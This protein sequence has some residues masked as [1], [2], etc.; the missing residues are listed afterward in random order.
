MRFGWLMGVRFRPA[1]AQG[2]SR[3]SSSTLLETTYRGN[4]APSPHPRQ[5][6]PVILRSIRCRVAA[7]SAGE[8]FTYLQ[9]NYNF[10]ERRLK[11]TSRG[12]TTRNGM[13]LHRGNGRP[14]S[15]RYV[16][17]NHGDRTCPTAL[18]REKTGTPKTRKIVKG[19]GEAAKAALH[20]VAANNK[21]AAQA[22]AGVRRKPAA[23]ADPAAA[24]M[25][26]AHL[27]GKVWVR[28]RPVAPRMVRIRRPTRTE[29]VGSRR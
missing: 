1:Q 9:P 23:G 2:F 5:R 18:Q 27:P 14:S 11:T 12:P 13:G 7:I 25:R 6:D 22:T 15:L 26:V 10:P 28:D 3:D 21:L 24:T 4:P 16:V 19:K 8:N 17:N 29:R 20:K